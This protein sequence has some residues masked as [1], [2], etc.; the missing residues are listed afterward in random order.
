MSFVD[1]REELNTGFA[2]EIDRSGNRSL[3]AFKKWRR[4]LFELETD[5]G[6]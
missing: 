1:N 6:I 5:Y 3:S 2:E 4:I